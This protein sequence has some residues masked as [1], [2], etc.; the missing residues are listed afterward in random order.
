MSTNWYPH[1]PYNIKY[2][3]LFENE[4]QRMSKILVGVIIEHF[5]STAVPNL[6]GK[7]YIDIYVVVDKND[8]NKTSKIIQEKLGYEYK[9]HASIK[10]KRLFYLRNTDEIR[11]HLHLTYTNNPDFIKAIKF[12]DYLRNHPNEAIEY[13]EIKKIASEKANRELTKENAKKVY[14]DTKAKLIDKIL[15]RLEK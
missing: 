3:K 4:K 8:L 5:G 7:G 6:E 9:E 1:T 12:R 2:P 14:M 10:N 15:D 11:Y 13:E